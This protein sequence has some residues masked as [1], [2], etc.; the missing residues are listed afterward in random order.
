MSLHLWKGVV[1]T[2]GQSVRRGGRRCLLRSCISR[3]CDGVT[4]CIVHSNSVR[5]AINSHWGT[6]LE[7]ARI[8]SSNPTLNGW[9]AF[10]HCLYTIRFPYHLAELD[11][12]SFPAMLQTIRAP[13]YHCSIPSINN[14]KETETGAYP[15]VARFASSLPKCASLR[16]RAWRPPKSTLTIDAFF[17]LLAILYLSL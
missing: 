7:E 11:S 2:T 9:S 6:H 12:P 8:I 13:T 17:P 16:I 5:S 3:S 4:F 14:S 1:V 15:C 10:C